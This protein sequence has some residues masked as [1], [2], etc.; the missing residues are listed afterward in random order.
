MSFSFR[1]LAPAI[2]DYLSAYPDV[3]IDLNLNDHYVDLVAERFDVAIC[4]ATLP[5]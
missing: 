5:T 3:S 2:A 4:V 1:H